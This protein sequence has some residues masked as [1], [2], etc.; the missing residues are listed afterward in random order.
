MAWTVHLKDS[1]IDD[2]RS[3]GKKDGRLLLSDPLAETRNMK[4]LRSNPVA[5]RA[6]RMFGKYRAMFNV[7]EETEQVIIILVGEK[8]GN[9][10]IVQEEEFMAH[11]ESDPAE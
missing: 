11:D 9:S 2:L 3:F 10:L 6:L 8:R 7:D 1:V 4:T 5:E